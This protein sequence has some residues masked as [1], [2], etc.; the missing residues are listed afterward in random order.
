MRLP[1]IRAWMF[2]AARSGSEGRVGS[3][4]RGS[5]RR[6]R[7]PPSKPPQGGLVG[8][9]RRRDRD[10]DQLDPEVRR[11]SPGVGLG[12]VAR[13]GGGHDD[14][15]DLLGPEGVHRDQGDQRR[16][17]PARERDRRHGRSRSSDVVAEPEHERRVDLGVVLERLA[18]RRRAARRRELAEEELLLELGGAGQHL[19]AG[20]DHEAVAVE[21][22]LV[23]A[24]DGVAE[25]EMR[26][27]GP[28]PFDEHPSRSRPLP[29]W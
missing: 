20:V 24:A 13:V 27:V 7:L 16:V 4:G 17:D 5:D 29:R 15:A 25:G 21:Y 10:L 12:L 26:P 22:E 11:R 23:L 14:A 3:R 1:R 8:L 28:R 2:S 18:Q 19:A 9:H 6:R